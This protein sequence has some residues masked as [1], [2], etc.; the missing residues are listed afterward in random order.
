MLFIV[1]IMQV[2]SVD[3]MGS[4]FFDIDLLFI[5]GGV[6]LSFGDMFVFVIVVLIEVV[7][8]V[9]I[10]FVQFVL[11]VVLDV[12][13]VCIVDWLCRCYEVGVLVV[14][15]NVVL[16]FV[17][18]GLFDGCW[19]MGLVS[20][21]VWFVWYFFGVCYMLDQLFVVDGWIIIVSGINFVVDVCVY[22]I[23]YCCGVGVLWWMLCMVFM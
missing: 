9:V 17:K 1:G 11:E 12:E 19:V 14:G 6:V 16:L 20:E 18:V 22:V 21:C 23:D 3:V 5:D 7:Y 13:E 8:D 15:M 4:W 2:C 10:V